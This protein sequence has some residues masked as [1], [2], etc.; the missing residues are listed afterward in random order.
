MGLIPVWIKHR[1]SR[2]HLFGSQKL[3][4]RHQSTY[5]NIQTSQEIQV[6]KLGFYWVSRARLLC[7][8]CTETKHAARSLYALGTEWGIKVSS[9]VLQVL[10]SG[11]SLKTNTKQ[12]KQKTRSWEWRTGPGSYC[13]KS[14]FLPPAHSL[15]LWG[16]PDASLAHS[17]VCRQC[18]YLTVV[19]SVY[20]VN[21]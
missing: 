13:L 12:N 4:Q 19:S 18:R 8:L 1:L 2:S 14:P 16:M 11:L 7:I 9:V 10:C 20:R 6:D 15:S 3:H 5:R 17:K 21:I